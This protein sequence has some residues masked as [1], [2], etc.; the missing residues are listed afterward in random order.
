MPKRKQRTDKILPTRHYSTKQEQEVAS[1]FNGNRTLNSGATPFSKGDVQIDRVSLEC[2]TKVKDSE[3]IT[4]HKEWVE[5]N[6][7]ESLFMGKPYSA[8]VFNFGPGQKNYYIID[9]D[10]FRILIDKL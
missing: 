6:E 2:K 1:K 7:R 9:E 8:V 4:V 10:M 3:S 5:K